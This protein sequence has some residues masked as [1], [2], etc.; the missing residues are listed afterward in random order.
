MQFLP[1]TERTKSRIRGGF[2]LIELLVVVAIIAI[3]ASLLL[4]ALAKA[5]AQAHRIQCLNNLK[6]LS[7]IWFLYA[8][9]YDDRLVINSDGELTQASWVQGSFA[10]VP[11]NATNLQMLLD[12]KYSLFG[13]YLKTTAVYKCPSDKVK[14]TGSGT[15]A[16]PRVRSYAMNGYLAWIGGNFRGV[17]NLQG[18]RMF[19]KMGE[20]SHP[21]PSMLMVFQ[22]V[23]PV[24][25]CRPVFGVYMGEDRFCHFPASNH[26][27]GGLT[28]FAD[29][30]V[31]SH[32]W[33]DVR[34]YKPKSPDFHRHND[35]SPNNVDLRWLQERTSSRL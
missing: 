35:A 4:P 33:L 28:S 9:D 13:P 15:L 21:S 16:H 2:T 12:P 34:T 1:N 6:Q 25:I 31:E 18:Y 7:T 10:T 22:D 17:P 8:G 27:R 30:H 3:L 20:L 14:G 19:R 32:R 24:S 29:G 11:S 23:N 26:N 5:K